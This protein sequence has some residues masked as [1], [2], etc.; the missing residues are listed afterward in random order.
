MI[1]RF[2]TRAPFLPLRRTELFFL[3]YGA[4]WFATFFIAKDQDIVIEKVI[5]FVKDFAI[6]LCVVYTLYTQPDWWRRLI[7]LIII[8]AG[9]LACL[10]TYQALTGNI[11]QTFFGFSKLVIAQIVEG[12]KDG[13]RLAGPLDDPNFWGQ[14][15]VSIFPLAL[16]RMMNE[17]K[18]ILKLTAAASALFMALAILNTY[19]R[20]A[21][22]VM[23]LVLLLVAIERRVKFSLII[24]VVPAI[25]LVMQFLPAGFTDRLQTLSMFTSEDS[26]V[27]SEISFRGRSS[28]MTSG[29][30]MFAD[31]PFLGVG[32]GNYIQYYQQYASR[33]GL[34][35]RT[36]GRR[37]HSTYLEIAAET[38]LPGLITFAGLFISVFAGLA[39]TRRKL[40]TLPNYQ[41]LISWITP[42]QIGIG[43]Y[44]TTSIFLHGDYIRY[45]W[46]L[47][48]LSVA[49]MHLADH[50]VST[51]K[52]PIIDS[53]PPVNIA[54]PPPNLW[55][56]Y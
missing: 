36:E 19:S 53:L 3:A 18:I 38:G 49:M 30:N 6:L 16:Y 52:P 39:Q 8:S 26:H 25:F 41:H 7:W 48:T 33:L 37:A 2:S 14:T 20:G 47:V 17:Q 51:Q 4:V 31:H 23:M 9:I 15:L 55:V 27:Q 22:M 43:A 10:G 34:E 13:G 32:V 50:L 35:Y 29:L 11:N 54:T 21:F 40:R 44:L 24:P 56:G 45:L 46:L 28:E 1:K 12:A 42:L 5:D